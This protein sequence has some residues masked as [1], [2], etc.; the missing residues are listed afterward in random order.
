MQVTM[1]AVGGGTT[2]AATPS[3]LDLLSTPTSGM[4][5]STCI[6]GFPRPPA[7]I[8]YAGSS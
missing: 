1:A 7:I 3:L 5:L 6:I 8:A 4:T 2:A